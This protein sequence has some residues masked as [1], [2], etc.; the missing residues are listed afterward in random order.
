VAPP[1]AP[2]GKGVVVLVGVFVP[3]AG[4]VAPGC[5]VVAGVVVAPPV[6]LVAGVA[7]P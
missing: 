2:V 5:V 1:P 3:V 7:E 4:A 6:V